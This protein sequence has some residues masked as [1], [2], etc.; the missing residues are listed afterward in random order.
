MA[1]ENTDLE[2]MHNEIHQRQAETGRL[3]LVEFDDAEYTA[4]LD[5]ARRIVREYGGWPPKRRQYARL[6]FL[7]CTMVFVRHNKYIDDNVFWPD[8]ESALGMGPMEQRF[9]MVD[10][11]L[12]P[13]YQEEGL[14]LTYDD[15]GRRIV[16]TLVDEMRQAHTWV[17]QARSQ[18]VEFFQWHYRHCPDAE[19]TPELLVA[20]EKQR[21]ARL[22]VLDKVLP[23]FARD[24]QALA[25]VIDY[26]IENGLY[27]EASRLSDYRRQIV[28][29]L[30]PEHDPARLRLIRD[31]RT[32]IRL[33]LDLQNHY[34]P[35]Q[36]ERELHRRRGGFVKSPGGERL[37]VHAALER[38]T[39]FP[40][41]IYQVEGQEYRIVPHPRLRLEMLDGWPYEQ[42]VHWQSGRFLGYKKP[43]SFQVTIGR[44]TVEAT[45]YARSRSDRTHVWMGEVPT[46]QKLAIDG[47]LRPESAGADWQIALGLSTGGTERPGL[48]VRIVR[49]MLYYPERPHQPLQVWAS[50]GYGYADTL[51]EDGVRRFHLHRCLVVPLD[52]FDA[53]VEVGVSIGDGTVL[54]QTFVPEPYYLFSATSHERVQ[55]RGTAD[56]GDREYVLFTRGDASPTAG[57]G[58]SVR[59]LPEPYGTYT[60]YQVAW[61]DA[62][63]PFELR[64]GAAQWAFQRRREFAVML[65]SQLPPPHLR[66]KPHQCLCFRDLSLRL[67]STLDLTAA[68]LTLEVYD[69]EGLLGQLNLSP[70]VGMAD[71]AHFFDVAPAVWQEVETLTGGRY[72]RYFLRFCAGETLLGESALSLMPLVSLES[73]DQA[74]PCLETQPLQVTFASL[75]C[76][77][78]DP[79]TGQPK[80]R[81]TFWL[82][83]RVHAEPWPGYPALRRIVS[84]PVPTLVSFPDLGETLEVIVHPR[85]FGFRLYL[86][87]PEEE[88]PGRWHTRYQPLSQADY[89]GLD[90]TALYVFSA[91]HSRVELTVGARAVWAGETDA[92]GD[93]L[94]D[95]LECLGP[96]CLGEET[97]VTVRSGNLR[98]EFV[99]RWAP[100]LLELAVEDEEVVLRFN[101][102]EDASVRL[103]LR[104]PSGKAFWTEDVPCQGEEATARIL[105]PADRPALGYL[106][107]GYVL[108]NGETR[109]AVWQVQVVGKASW[110]VPLSWLE[111]GI[112]IAEEQ[113]MRV[114]IG[115]LIC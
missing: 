33:I 24:C 59:R 3:S 57:P 109:P 22:V 90:A 79:E 42:V 32:L 20:Y 93:L 38:W 40:Y 18:F 52:A 45:P 36:F 103:W 39:P 82:R 83:P 7:A 54:H 80:H 14:E 15:R 31:E 66:L 114:L 77:V 4:M 96:A 55:A 110:Y 106:V 8:F 28:T 88:S 98:S 107:A 46:G 6:V 23:A 91:P 26:A 35:A 2:A 1:F 10:E 29:A 78:W 81:A 56:L 85:L 104:K 92:A 67:Y 53:P 11:L 70:H 76:L 9:L 72:G 37:N 21:R 27:L 105:L 61:E 34:T 13:A 87:R 68:A 99:V 100:L 84:E 50:T 101:G 43:S 5:W 102:P 108:S 60:V 95:T 16:G 94:I 64:V 111:E 12:W 89:Y 73:W 25:C 113:D 58:V 115:L 75:D 62:D 86:K 48:C 19:I 65:S 49:L 97:P 69:E 74:A 112:G 51:R 41:G 44:R 17:T 71:T 63:R 30:G 47:H